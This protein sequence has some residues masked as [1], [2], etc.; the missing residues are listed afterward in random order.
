[1]NKKCYIV[2]AG[3]NSGTNFTKKDNELVIAVDGGLQILQDMNIIPDIIIGDFDS[4]GYVPDGE[5]VIKH[6][7][8]K[9]DTDT[10]LAVKYAIENGY[11]D[12]EIFGGTGG[13]IDHTIANLQT[14]LFASQK[15]VSIKMIDA[16]NEYVVITDSDIE[17]M[18]PKGKGLAVFAMGGIASGVNIRNAEY[19]AENITLKPDNP[20][21]VSNSFIGKKV[22]IS[23]DNGSLL[24]IYEKYN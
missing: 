4:L 22:E 18:E 19:M 14:M 12:I 11:N 24:I 17:L 23:V 15:G 9:D 5:N 7:I 2:G 16:T 20:M 10:M 1:M 3:D 8:K 13:R 21:G 6:E